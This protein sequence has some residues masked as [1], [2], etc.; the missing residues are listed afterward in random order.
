M[1]GR[2]TLP[3]EP[4]RWVDPSR[5]IWFVT[6]CTQPRGLN[7][8]VQPDLWPFLAESLQRRVEIGAWWLHL[9]VSMPDHCHALISFPPN[10]VMKKTMAD[11][12]RWL[13][14][15]RGI[16]WQTD[17]FDHRL[18]AEESFEEKY[19]YILDNPVRAGFVTNA[20]DWP[21]VWRPAGAAPFTGLHR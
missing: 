12:K 1:A 16:R 17:F 8:L 6:V 4:P 10:G 15:Q 19:R 21:Y 9:F 14:T 11:W 13:A 3:H 18:R 5:E 20:E 7:Q 2:K